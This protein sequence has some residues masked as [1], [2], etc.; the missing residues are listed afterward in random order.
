MIEVLS[1]YISDK[2]LIQYIVWVVS[3][4][5]GCIAIYKFFIKKIENI[6]LNK[7]E[8]NYDVR[9]ICVHCEK[10]ISNNSESCV[11]CG[12]SLPFEKSRLLDK[13]EYIFNK[14]SWV[15]RNYPMAIKNKDRELIINSYIALPVFTIIIMVF[16]YFN[17]DKDFTNPFNIALF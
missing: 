4:L 6:S 7:V 17:S 2:I 8:I 13:A 3:I 15:A 1:E 10:Y 5:S 16:F 14:I 12:N 9:G 11:Y